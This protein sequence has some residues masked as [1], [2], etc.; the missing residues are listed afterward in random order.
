MDGYT[1][2]AL[3]VGVLLLSVM[4]AGCE[5]AAKRVE[6]L[7]SPRNTDEA[8]LVG[9]TLQR[10]GESLPGAVGDALEY[11]GWGIGAA[12]TIGAGIYSRSCRKKRLKNLKEAQ[13]G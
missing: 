3:A 13:P 4:L 9:Q 5:T 6:G 8:R 2:K 10:A 7:L 1:R 11:V 12:A